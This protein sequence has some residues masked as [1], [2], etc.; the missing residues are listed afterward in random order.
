MAISETTLD[1][2]MLIDE[3]NKKRARG[4]RKLEPS[5]RSRLNRFCSPRRGN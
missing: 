1:V 4:K 2:M 3:Q 5:G